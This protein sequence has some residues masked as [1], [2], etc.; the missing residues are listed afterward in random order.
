MIRR[1]PRST[2][3]DTLFPYTTRFRS[4]V[5]HRPE[6]PEAAVLVL[7]L[8][9]L[10]DEADEELA[11]APDGLEPTV[12]RAVWRDDQDG[13]VVGRH[14]PEPRTSAELST[15]LSRLRVERGLTPFYALRCL[16]LVTP[17]QPG[18]VH[19]LQSI[20]VANPTAIPS[21]TPFL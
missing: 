13:E 1:P 20:T 7:D 14:E 3:P 9:L 19:S 12:H 5:Q 8:E 18:P 6:E 21:V 11:V 15:R 2:R 16:S 17:D 4:G 10:A